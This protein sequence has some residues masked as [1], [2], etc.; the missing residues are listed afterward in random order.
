MGEPDA[1][2]QDAIVRTVASRR[3][4][5]YALDEHRRGVTDDDVGE[6]Q[7]HRYVPAARGVGR[8]PDRHPAASGCGSRRSLNFARA[9][10]ELG[11]RNWPCGQNPG[12]KPAIS[13]RATA[14]ETQEP[15]RTGFDLQGQLSLCR[16]VRA[17]RRRHQELPSAFH[18]SGTRPEEYGPPRT[19]SSTTECPRAWAPRG[20]QVAGRAR[21]LR[22]QPYAVRLV[23]TFW[24][25]C[26]THRRRAVA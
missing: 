20:R 16:P 18:S 2:R 15:R 23:V 9:P 12:R 11:C 4:G 21:T 3:R 6:G 1:G 14:R 24:N 26:E 10:G 8:R 17:V 13:R 25:P 22:V 5:A 19:R 7:R